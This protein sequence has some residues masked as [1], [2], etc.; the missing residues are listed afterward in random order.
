MGVLDR[1]F[2]KKPV[3]VHGKLHNLLT[4][5]SDIEQIRRLRYLIRAHYAS[6]SVND[7]G[8]TDCPLY[9]SSI[10]GIGGATNQTVAA[11]KQLPIPNAPRDYRMVAGCNWVPTI[12][13]YDVGCMINDFK[14]ENCRAVEKSKVSAGLTELLQQILLESEQHC[15]SSI[16]ALLQHGASRGDAYL[17]PRLDQY[18]PSGVR[19]DLAAA[20]GVFPIIS[21][22]NKTEASGYRL[23]YQVQETDLGGSPE[24]TP[25]IGDL[26]THV[27]L[28]GKNGCAVFV[29]GKRDADMS[30]ELPP[31]MDE[32]P[33]VHVAHR[34]CGDFFGVPSADADFIAGIDD[35]NV[36][37]ANL[38]SVML[39][40]FGQPAVVITGATGSS[41][42]WTRRAVHYLP[43]DATVE[44]LAYKELDKLIKVI[45]EKDKQLRGRAPQ[46]VLLDLRS[47]SA[48]VTS[49]AAMLVRL[50]AYDAYLAGLERQYTKA[51]DE[52]FRKCAKLLGEYPAHGEVSVKIEWGAR[53]PR[54]IQ[55]M[56]KELE[57]HVKTF[58]KIRPVIERAARLAGYEES[59]IDEI[60]SNAE[61]DNNAEMKGKETAAHGGGAT[62]AVLAGRSAVPLPADGA[63]AVASGGKPPATFIKSA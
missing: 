40:S 39:Y 27:Q 14:L 61:R 15:G 48:S 33:I 63:K 55:D 26:K 28:V 24:S 12:V 13:D 58:G 43:K 18:I 53:F 36:A 35:L 60:V 7:D 56:M 29:D 10:E 3:D 8:Q 17:Y 62:G 49:G 32:V 30:G 46:L 31:T 59:A 4:G 45:E 20:E 1:F 57:Q 51:I 37:W 19:V 54:D 52:L 42:P 9:Y 50:F 38:N 25:V 21:K 41:L 11:L 5:L 47:S 2:G 22:W 34:S 6:P 23:V 16:N 44:I